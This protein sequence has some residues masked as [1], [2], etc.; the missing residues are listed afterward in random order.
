MSL[1]DASGTQATGIILIKRKACVPTLAS[2]LIPSR[3]V[4]ITEMEEVAIRNVRIL[5]Y[6]QTNDLSHY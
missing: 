5:K 4:T 2:V 3:E 1:K 6:E